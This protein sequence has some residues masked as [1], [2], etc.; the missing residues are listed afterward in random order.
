MTKQDDKLKKLAEILE[1]GTSKASCKAIGLLREEPSFRG[2][3][4]LFASHYNKTDDFEIRKAIEEFLNDLKDQSVTEEIIAELRKQ[5]KPE[6]LTML[7]SSC[8]QSGLDYSEY[9]FDIA[10]VFIR[11]D[12][13]TAFECLTLIEETAHELSS[14][15]KAEILEL[16]GRHPISPSSEKAA[17]TS[18]LLLI[19]KR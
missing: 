1:K 3:V 8:W 17:L 13:V 5:W 10:E 11:G 9:T 15:K 16:L 12:Y 4:G 14:Q 18:E 7:V 6:T 19:L 2:V